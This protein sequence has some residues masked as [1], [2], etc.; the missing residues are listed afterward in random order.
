LRFGIFKS[1]KTKDFKDINSDLAWEK[2]R[3][4]MT[5]FP[6]CH[7]GKQRE[8]SESKLSKDE[9]AEIWINN[10]EDLQVKLKYVGSS[11]TNDH[12]SSVIQFNS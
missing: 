4:N 12:D 5:E 7:W 9:Y 11:M 6:P 3:K 2:L 10:L 8:Y 1:F